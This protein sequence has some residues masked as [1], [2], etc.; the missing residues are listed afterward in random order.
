MSYGLVWGCA[1][2]SPQPLGS[3]RLDPHPP[4]PGE[5]APHAF[6]SCQPGGEAPQAGGG[7]E[8]APG[9][10]PAGSLRPGA[11]GSGFGW[12]HPLAFG[13]EAGGGGIQMLS[14]GSGCSVEP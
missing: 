6:G 13:A 9:W 1:Q 4:L 5:E 11:G 12:A 14:S 2:G 3:G 8:E 10:G 7:A